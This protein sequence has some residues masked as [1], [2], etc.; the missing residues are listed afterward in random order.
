MSAHFSSPADNPTAWLHELVHHLEH[1][2]PAQAPIKDFVHHNTLHGF[3]HLPFREALAAAEAETGAH[4]FQPVET[5]RAYFRQGRIDLSDLNTALDETPEL[6]AEALLPGGILRRDVLLTGLLFDLSPLTANTLAWHIEDMGALERFQ[7]GVG[8][9]AQA[10]VLAELPAGLSSLWSTCQAVLGIADDPAAESIERLPEEDEATQQWSERQ[11]KHE[12]ADQL[13][14]LLDRVGRDLSLRGLLLTLTGRDLMDE[15]RPYL[16]RHLAA[17]LDQGM[18]AWH[19]PAR[20]QG[21]YAAW[22]ASARNDPH[23]ELNDLPS[24]KSIS[25]RLPDDPSACILQKLQLLGL[26]AARW[27]DYL[28]LLAKEL[29]GW[30]GMVLWRHAHPGY[31][32]ETTPIDML[33]YLAI[34]LVLERAYA[35][36]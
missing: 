32:G 36:R 10:R 18:A 31:A 24:W 11:L 12:A 5:F 35:A 2:L 4:G 33:D 30:S 34:R 7:D 9:A 21:L 1:V 29:P 8:E 14:A 19:N 23:F 15:L 22:L 26:P 20:T 16:V 25:E 3:Q 17:H 27:A 13:A 6:R 28:G